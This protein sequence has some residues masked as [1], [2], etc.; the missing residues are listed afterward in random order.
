MRRRLTRNERKRLRAEARSD[1]ESLLRGTAGGTAS[2]ITDADF[3]GGE[4]SD[5]I[6]RALAAAGTDHPAKLDAR[7]FIA[8]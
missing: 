1:A 3:S 4:Y 2:C 8:C 6:S 5:A 7:E